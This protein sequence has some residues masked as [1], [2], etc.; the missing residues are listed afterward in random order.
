MNVQCFK[1]RM[2]RYVNFFLCLTSG[3]HAS[4]EIG[5]AD[6]EE[7]QLPFD[8]REKG[9]STREKGFRPIR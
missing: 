3:V 9:L 2:R 6:G 4:F 1:M 7:Y 5:D 8:S